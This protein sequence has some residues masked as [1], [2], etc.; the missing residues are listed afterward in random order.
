MRPSREAPAASTG[1][2]RTGVLHN[3]RIH[4]TMRH[5]VLAAVAAA[6]LALPLIITGSAT[7]SSSADHDSS[8]RLAGGLL[9]PVPTNHAGGIGVTSAVQ[10]GDTVDVRI[11]VAGLLRNAPHAMHIHID[12]QG[13]CPTGRDATEHNGRRAISTVDGHHAYGRIGTSLTTSGDTSPASAL[14]IDRFPSQG[15]FT[16]HRS[17]DVTPEV[18]ENLKAGKAV[19]VVHGIDYNKNGTYDGVLGASQLDPALPLEA[20]APALCGTLK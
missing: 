18:L 2:L 9:R 1:G 17:I 12:G 10:R 4:R 11:V 8:T 19:V 5:S 20:T 16:Y 13:E 7:A 14:A 15:T 6:G 3:G